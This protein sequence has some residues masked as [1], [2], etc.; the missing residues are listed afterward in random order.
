MKSV[1]VWAHSAEVGS[2][3]ARSCM[4]LSRQMSSAVK[5]LKISK[6]DAIWYLAL[7]AALTIS[8]MSGL[9]ALTVSEAY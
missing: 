6:K 8:V 7:A 1:I 3:A 4:P 5:I 2:S 9:N